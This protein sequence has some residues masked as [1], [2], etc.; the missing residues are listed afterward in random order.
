MA[1][2]N[3]HAPL[4]RAP[5]GLPEY[6]AVTPTALAPPALQLPAVPRALV[7]H[8]ATPCALPL[9]IDV[10]LA[11]A[12]SEAGAGLLL[13]YQL[14]GDLSRMRVPEPAS[15]GPADGLWQRTCFEAFVARAGETAYR[16]FNFSPSGRW[17]AYRFSAERLRDAAAEAA[18]APVVPDLELERGTDSLTLL[19]WLPLRALPDCAQGLPMEIGLTAVI[20]TTDGQLSYW[21]LRHPA[22]RPDF[23][24]RGGFV[25]APDL[26]HFPLT[27]APP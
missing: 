8:P 25:L 23:H 22:E 16:E 13:R 10:S 1:L 26:P 27:T 3:H 18:Q 19:A 17:A 14:R 4:V 12:G 9:Q 6:G 21:A 20:E 15:P 5:R 11:A 7:C 2:I 24:H